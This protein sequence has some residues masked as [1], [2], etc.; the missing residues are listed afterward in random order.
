MR[1]K[2]L[3]FMLCFHTSEWL[4]LF[5]SVTL[6]SSLDYCMTSKCLFTILTVRST[7]HDALSPS[8]MDYP[9]M[10]YP[11]RPCHYAL[12]SGQ[13]T[14]AAIVYKSKVWLLLLRLGEDPE[15]KTC[16]VLKGCLQPPKENIKRK[17]KRPGCGMLSSSCL[18]TP[19]R[20]I[21]R[22]KENPQ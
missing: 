6:G 7:Q 18:Q 20:W 16:M 12:Q 13:C 22:Y 5:V 2:T 4:W 11:P 10:V 9:K 1:H 21:R 15:T 17:R 8:V 19:D 14:V 3:N